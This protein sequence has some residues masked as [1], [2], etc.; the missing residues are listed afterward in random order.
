MGAPIN[1]QQIQQEAAASG[2]PPL[3]TPP[4]P[5]TPQVATPAAAP[6][7]P[8]MKSPLTVVSVANGKITMS[9]GTVY[10][11]NG[12]TSAPAQGPEG[13][14]PTNPA[15]GSGPI[16]GAGPAGPSYAPPGGAANS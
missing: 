14:T 5:K 6:V 2:G 7:Q 3:E 15:G 13:P 16:G 1:Y 12:L 9:D 11:A 10:N 4:T 8:A